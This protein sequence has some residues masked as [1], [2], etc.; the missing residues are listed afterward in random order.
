MIRELLHAYGQ[1][2]RREFDHDRLSTLGSSG[3]G[4]CIRQ[5]AFSLLAVPPDAGFVDSWGAALR[6][7]VYEDHCWV[8]ALRSSLPE[9]VEL[10]FAGEDQVTMVDEE[11]RLSATPDGLIV[12]L[13]RWCLADLGVEDCLA[14]SVLVECKTADPRML[15]RK[16]RPHHE[17]Q[18][19]MAMG[20]VRRCTDFAPEY[21]VISYT[22]ASF[23]DQ[24][25]EFPV[26][27]S[28]RV[29]AAGAERARA[30]FAATDPQRCRPK[31][32]WRAATNAS[33]AAGPVLAVKPRCRAC[34]PAGCD[35]IQRRWPNLKAC[36]MPNGRWR[37]P[38]TT[39]ARCV[40][41]PRKP[42]SGSCTTTRSA[43]TKATAGR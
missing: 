41:S 18:V 25:T 23:W 40:W 34:P 2:R 42:S 6:G 21:A 8:P 22:N 29:Y 37:V 26:R 28:E 33:I 12:G 1:S 35:W 5:T 32:S 19:Q 27:Y 7:T 3:Q 11:A 15:L 14:D 43:L 9:G 4:R 20:L 24:V 30:V 39:T 31:A 16:P 36:A 38:S 17:F 13:P 10:L